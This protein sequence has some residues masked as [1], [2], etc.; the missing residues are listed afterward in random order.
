M[1]KITG[2]FIPSDTTVDVNEIY[3]E[4]LYKPTKFILDDITTPHTFE[5]LNGGLTK[6]NFAPS[7]VDSGD[8][9][10]GLSAEHFRSGSFARGYFYG[11]NFPDRYTESQY[12]QDAVANTSVFGPTDLEETVRPKK[13]YFTPSYS[14]SANVFLP[15]DAIVYVSYQGFFS[16]ALTQIK[17]D[18]VGGFAF[19][20][21]EREDVGDESLHRLY[22]DGVY[23]MGTETR[24]P[25]SNTEHY[26][27]REIRY[28]WH[29]KTKLFKL[30]KG[31]HD[32]S[33]M[34]YLFLQRWSKGKETRVLN[35]LCGSLSIVAIKVGQERDANSSVL[36]WYGFDT[37]NLRS[38]TER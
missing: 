3:N 10:V 33:V 11:F 31:Y 27:S 20:K 28:R 2:N 34:I 19:D 29:N 21:S 13:R 7:F 32:F 5:A 8:Y 1:A 4:C 24:C 35:N 23:E 18:I 25:A 6:E 37:T 12:N 30:D 15:W 22:V 14:M 9:G 38:I 16:Q 17:D 36:E 26:S